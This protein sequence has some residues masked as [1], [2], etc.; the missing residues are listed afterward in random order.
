MSNAD[1]VNEWF[2]ER[3]ACGAL[4][5]DTD[6]YNQVRTALPELI[7]RLDATVVAE[8]PPAPQAPQAPAPKQESDA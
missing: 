5:R 6:A 3:L 7:Q 4:G 2:R 1:I 8:S